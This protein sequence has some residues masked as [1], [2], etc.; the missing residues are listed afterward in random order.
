MKT[1]VSMWLI[2][3]L[4]SLVIMRTDSV[5]VPT[6]SQL[7]WIDDEISVLISWNMATFVSP[8][9]CPYNAPLPDPRI[10]RPTLV[11][12][13]NW[14]RTIQDLGA[15]S[16]TLVVRHGCGF[17]T[18]PSS[19]QLPEPYSIVYNYSIAYADESVSNRD[20]VLEF[21]ESCQRNGIKIGLYFNMF[22]NY[23]MNIVQGEVHSSTLFP[24]QVNVTTDEF[25]NVSIAQLAELIS[26][27]YGQLNELWF[28][29]GGLRQSQFARVK[30]L[31]DQYQ[32]QVNV[33]SQG[34]SNISRNV[35]R[36]SMTESGYSPDPNWST[37]FDCTQGPGQGDPDGTQFCVVMCDTTLQLDDRWFWRP[38]PEVSGIRSLSELIDVY[39]ATV[40]HNCLLQLDLTPDTNGLIPPLY[41]QRYKQLGD[42][43]R[44]CYTENMRPSIN[45]TC[46]QS[47]CFLLFDRPTT[48]DRLV[49]RED[50]QYGQLIRAYQIDIQIKTGDPWL[51]LLNG[52]SIGNKKIDLFKDGPIEVLSVRLT[53]T[54]IAPGEQQSPYIR[55]FTAHLCA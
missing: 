23:F 3:V 38:Y 2:V 7:S 47:Q 53:A 39:H 46:S 33:M 40:G 18:Y 25:D 55:Q 50:Q 32:P 30:N 31:I 51:F 12:T 13:D 48:I 43:I 5:P 45:S 15:R 19:V 49:L 34:T 6:P 4:A 52:T 10:F 37:S 11:N 27:H 17:V 44:S 21:V 8:D 29:S 9:W 35:I 1:S 26:G 24:Y 42:F 54:Q 16:A 41:A 14:V 36:N 28:D 22:Y 20:L